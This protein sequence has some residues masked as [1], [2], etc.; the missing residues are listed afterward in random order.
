MKTK[1]KN[2]FLTFCFSI[3]PGAG[4]MYMGFMRTG[5]SLML[6]FFIS[7]AVPVWLNLGALVVLAAI[8]WFYGFFHA[9]HLAGLSDE[10]FA[11]AQDEY[12]FG[13]D[14]LSNGKDFVSKYH[15]WVAAGL[16][17]AGCCLLWN[18]FT[19]IAYSFL[20]EIVYGIL[21]SIGGYAPSILVA[22]VIIYIGVKMISGKQAE[23]AEESEKRNA[24][25]Q[26][27]RLELNQEAEV[28]QTKERETGIGE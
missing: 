19:S 6:L 14:A 18:T 22:I 15:K 12:L 13:M 11:E 2:R 1:K 26:T 28:N 25:N 20:P 21:R 5:V 17:F 7:I 24:A 23:L 10:D 9:N 4:E 8:V 16:I 27:E 3:I